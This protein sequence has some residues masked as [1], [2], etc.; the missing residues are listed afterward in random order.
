MPIKVT[1]PKC[2]H[3]LHAPDDAGGK[4]GRC[5]NCTTVLT[6][7][8]ESP[9][10]GRMPT[11]G[12][13]SQPPGNPFRPGSPLPTPGGLKE[14]ADLSAQ[15]ARSL[16]ATEP[17]VRPTG[18]GTYALKEP[19]PRFG[20]AGRVPGA[21]GVSANPAPPAV[22]IP[23]PNRSN[24]LGSEISPDETQEAAI[25]GWKRVHRG[26]GVIRLAT[27]LAILA[28][29]AMT[30]RIAYEQFVGPL[31]E[32]PGLLKLSQ[33]SLAEE[34]RIAVVAIPV[35]LAVV[36]TLF[37]RLSV[38]RAPRSAYSGGLG[39]ASALAT[40]L[41]LVGLI[42]AA[43]PSIIEIIDDTPIQ[44]WMDPDT[45]SG[46]FQRFGLS[47][48]GLLL[49]LAEVWLLAGLGNMG[50]ALQDRRLAGRSSRLL[51][52]AGLV[53]MLAV[54]GTVGYLEYGS[55]L[56]HLWNIHVEPHWQQIAEY[57]ALARSGGVALIGLFIG[58]VYL[59]LIGAGRAAVGNW[60]SR[61]SP[62]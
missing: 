10:T 18:V 35:G 20:P 56:Q 7:P 29:L 11:A 19:E 21:A 8:T 28:P 34:I 54:A 60:L 31:P 6:I 57:Q 12:G 44:G 48:G 37:G 33:F 43:F 9:P 23:E 51:I 25:R 13:Q 17:E 5:P 49:I 27:W 39:W 45:Q 47:L 22:R 42:L 16:P 24:L 53:A 50:A 59:R 36:L 32:Q 26:L 30:C 40:L 2:G 1:C 46:M 4:R 15:A 14:T 58:T 62:K 61:T 52:L 41:G 3:V 55:K 38:A